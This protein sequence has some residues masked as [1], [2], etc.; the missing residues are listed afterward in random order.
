MV[1]EGINPRG[2]V[3]S[4]AMVTEPVPLVLEWLTYNGVRIT[5]TSVG[6]R[7]EVIDVL[8]LAARHNLRIKTESIPL[9][10]INEGLQRLA[11]GNVE[12]RLVVDF[13]RSGAD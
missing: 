8:N 12:G 10:T 7:Q 9:E 1:V 11:A 5:G 4:V 13:R 2:W 6:T 3:I